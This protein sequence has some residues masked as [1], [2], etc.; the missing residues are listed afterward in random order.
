MWEKSHIACGK[1]AAGRGKTEKTFYADR[2][3]IL[4]AN[5]PPA[6]CNFD[7]RVIILKTNFALTQ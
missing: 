4:T 3:T 1:L 5:L 2:M 6:I 7:D